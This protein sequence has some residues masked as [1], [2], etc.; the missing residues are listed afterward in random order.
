MCCLVLLIV[1]F[2]CSS[3]DMV[4]GGTYGLG[5]SDPKLEEDKLQMIERYARKAHPVLRDATII[6]KSVGF[7]P[8][9]TGGVRIERDDKIIGDRNVVV[10]MK[11]QV[12]VN[13]CHI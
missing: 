10:S 3:H 1:F 5:N 7:R 13:Y 8:L 9:R 11:L 6:Q 2:D 12:H 4:V